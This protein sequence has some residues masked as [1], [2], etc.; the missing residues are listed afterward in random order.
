MHPDT[1]RIFGTQTVP[2]LDKTSD[3]AG[4]SLLSAAPASVTPSLVARRYRLGSAVTSRIDIHGI[5]PPK[6][7]GS[8]FG[9]GEA[10]RI[11]VIRSPSLAR[12]HPCGSPEAQ[13]MPPMPC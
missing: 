9:R 11:T 4:S 13:F 10:P 2:L 3:P 12:A 7:R 1:A 8:P 6:Y 5:S